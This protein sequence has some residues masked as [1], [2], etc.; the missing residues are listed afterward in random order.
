MPVKFQRVVERDDVRMRQARV[1]LDLAE[2]PLQ[3]FRVVVRGSRQRPQDFELAR[4]QVPNLVSNSC[5]GFVDD[6]KELIVTDDLTGFGH[7]LGTQSSASLRSRAHPVN[8]PLLE[9]IGPNQRQYGSVKCRE[10]D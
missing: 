6:T 8:Y 4:S 3:R 2:K 7:C 10:G 1:D 5:S 9:R